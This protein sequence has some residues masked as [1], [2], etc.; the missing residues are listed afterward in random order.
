MKALKY[1]VAI[2][3]VTGSLAACDGS[4]NKATLGGTA[5]TSAKAGTGK[6]AKTMKSDS[7][8][9]DTTYKGNADPAGHGS[10]DSAKNK[11]IN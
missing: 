9:K 7:A 8:K 6:D 5:D 3:L 10:S 2:V 4:R 11:P 1:F